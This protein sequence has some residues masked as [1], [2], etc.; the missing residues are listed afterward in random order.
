VGVCGWVYVGGWVG[1]FLVG[2]WAGAVREGGLVGGM[3]AGGWV[4]VGG[5][6]WVW[7]DEWIATVR[8]QELHAVLASQSNKGTTCAAQ[9]QT[10]RFLAVDV[11]R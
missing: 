4:Y 5:W 1:G 3:W 9:Y 6:V 10:S 11:P 7:V 2:Q 8:S